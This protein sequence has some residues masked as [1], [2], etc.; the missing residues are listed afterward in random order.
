[1]ILRKLAEALRQQSWFTAVLEVFIV[2]VG[3]FIGLQADS[4]NESRKTQILEG[5]YLERLHDDFSRSLAGATENRDGLQRQYDSLG[6]VLERLKSCRLDDADLDVFTTGLMRLAQFTPEPLI[7]GTIDELGSTGRLDVISDLELRNALSEAVRQSDASKEIVGFIVQRVSLP[8]AYVD[9]KL[10][11]NL[12]PT[13]EVISVEGV[14]PAHRLEFDFPAMCEDKEFIG[15]VSMIQYATYIL[16][17][18]N[19]RAMEQYL[20]VVETLERELGYP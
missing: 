3:I 12:P 5:Q 6:L 4:W 14:V 8:T 15:S 16:V 20:G 11:R 10:V 17:R 1:M 18:Y 19:Q 9:S 2:V 13:D 7:R